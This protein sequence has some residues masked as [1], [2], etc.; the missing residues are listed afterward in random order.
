MIR[1][2]PIF[3]RNYHTRVTETTGQKMRLNKDGSKVNDITHTQRQSVKSCDSNFFSSVSVAQAK[4]LMRI[5]YFGTR[6][7]HK[8]F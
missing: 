6:Y 2:S 4:I 8:S 3:S 7:R 1:G 5:L